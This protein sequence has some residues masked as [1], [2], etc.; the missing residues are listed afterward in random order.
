MWSGHTSQP[1]NIP[2]GVR[3]GGVSHPSYMCLFIDKIFPHNLALIYL[4]MAYRSCSIEHNKPFQHIIWSCML[5]HVGSPRL[6]ASRF[7][8]LLDVT[9]PRRIQSGSEP[10]L[11]A[12]PGECEC[13]LCGATR[14]D[15]NASLHLHLP[16]P[17]VKGQHLSSDAPPLFG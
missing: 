4:Y 11:S 10:E 17:Q 14:E 5:G 6:K 15:T 8:F 12:A 3:Q 13:N 16:C 7:T 9:G 2:Q 1:L